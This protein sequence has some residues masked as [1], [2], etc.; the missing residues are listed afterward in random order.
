[1]EQLTPLLQVKLFWWN[2]IDSTKKCTTEESILYT[3]LFLQLLGWVQSSCLEGP[4]KICVAIPANIR[5]DE[6]V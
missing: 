3:I 4:Q 1:M 6:D 5:L 2:S